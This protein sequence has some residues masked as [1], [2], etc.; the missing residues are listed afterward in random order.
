LRSWREL[1]F[2]GPL[3]KMSSDQY[4]AG[5]RAMVEENVVLKLASVPEVCTGLES[6]FH[7]CE[8]LLLWRW[9]IDPC[10]TWRVSA[11]VLTLRMQDKTSYSP[12]RP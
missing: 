12:I 4:D 6:C 9:L 2:G 11:P 10:Q 3:A 7:G 1:A 8:S 5:L